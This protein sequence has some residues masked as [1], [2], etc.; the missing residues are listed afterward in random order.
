[1]SDEFS[2]Y[3]FNCNVCAASDHGESYL[4][5]EI[6]ECPK[7]GTRNM[8]RWEAKPNLSREWAYCEAFGHDWQVPPGRKTDIERCTM[9]AATRDF[10]KKKVDA[11]G[12][13]AG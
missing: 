8:T 4:D 2:R 11:G 3:F 1:M 5:F 6:V 12:N 13:G 7:C 9:C 10:S